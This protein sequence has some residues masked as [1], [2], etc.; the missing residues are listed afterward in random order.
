MFK[1]CLV[2]SGPPFHPKLPIGVEQWVSAFG[3]NLIEPDVIMLEC[4]RL[5]F[6]LIHI[7]CCPENY[8]LLAA[9]RNRLGRQSKT[10][11]ALS[12]PS[13]LNGQ[14]GDH[15]QEALTTACA[16]ADLLFA[17]DYATALH[18]ERISKQRVYT[19]PNP[20]DLRQICV[21]SDGAYTK[22]DKIAF[23][24]EHERFDAFHREFL[25]MQ[26]A[27]EGCDACHKSYEV[28]VYGDDVWGN[29]ELLARLGQFAF[30]CFDVDLVGHDEEL[31]YL[32]ARGC[33]IVGGGRAEVIKR[34]F[35][36]SAHLTATETLRTL[37]W[38][39]SDA[40][41]KK[42][43]LECAADK[44]EYYNHG[45]S[46]HRFITL[47]ANSG[48]LNTRE[49]RKHPDVMRDVNR[50]VYLDAINHV[51]G[52][53]DFSYNSDEFV[54]VCL[55]KNGMEYLPSFLRHY[56]A[57]GAKH[58]YFIDN[59]SSDATRTVL[60]EQPDV[61]LYRTAL[62][63]KRFESE[64]RRAIIEIHCGSRWC[65]CVDIDE[66]FDF[67]GSNKLTSGEFLNY[68]RSNG[69]T[70]VVAYMLDMFATDQNISSLYLED[71]YTDF[72]LS[73]IREGDYFFG[74]EVFC[75]NNV[76]PSPKICNYYGGVRQSHIPPGESRFLLTKHPL[77]FIDHHMEPVTMPHFCD[78]SRVAD[79][80]CLLKHYKLTFSLK[81]R[82]EEGIRTDS[83]SFI[84][85]DQIAA[86]LSLTSGAS[87]INASNKSEVFTD[88]WRLVENGFL[89]A[90]ER[91]R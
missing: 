2:K 56:R 49:F 44:I 9:I 76:L 27:R 89:F 23:V 29:P 37:H 42:F 53:I 51:S 69:F 82:I 17:V 63:H 86:Y 73:S 12:V 45:N 43:A 70:S 71:I 64:I 1:Y 24:M 39:L 31:I 32:T 40:S 62:M 15:E 85:K 18:Y 74:F 38:L 11:I 26:L 87:A 66:L 75:A 65:M 57:I 60:M 41:A 79:V 16:Q 88:V 10:I 30:I 83:Y 80:T 90:S 58:F 91:Y 21:E 4:E 22:L 52:P 68:L 28:E 48:V 36:F 13:I 78:K 35:C 81:A 55:V 47:L 6:D 14:F 19:L 5:C 54:V 33:A 34:C 7:V 84:I 61:T 8:Q 20:A 3:G 25:E 59:E 77:I 67:P 50:V 46:R 72:D